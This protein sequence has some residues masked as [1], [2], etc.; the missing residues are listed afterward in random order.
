MIRFGS[1]VLDRFWPVRTGLLLTQ[2]TYI[3]R[4][5]SRPVPN[6][7]DWI[8]R[9]GLI[10]FQNVTLHY[11]ISTVCWSWE[12]CEE[13]MKIILHLWKKSTSDEQGST[14]RWMLGT[15]SRLAYYI[16][17]IRVVGSYSLWLLYCATQLEF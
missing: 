8:D 16:E 1:R 12:T 17:I 7:T 11:S 13:S 6:L 15:T 2:W 14:I 9:S 5:D 3:I 4:P 10:N